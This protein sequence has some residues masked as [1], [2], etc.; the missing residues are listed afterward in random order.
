MTK[1]S[2]RILVI[3]DNP[4]IHND[5]RKILC[6]EPRIS[7]PLEAAEARLFGELRRSR[8]IV[9]FELDSAYQGQEGLARVFHALQEGH[10]YEIAFVDVRMPPGWDGIEVTPRLWM[11]DPNLHIVICTAYSDYSWEEMFARVGASDRM[12]VLKKPFDRDECLQLVHT[13]IAMRESAGGR[14]AP[15]RASRDESE[16]SEKFQT[17]ILRMKNPPEGQ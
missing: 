9:T 16:F 11:A 15:G 12:F 10:P 1:P 7:S 17:E 13:I 4:E 3:D 5:F 14:Y 2:H 6:S 8:K